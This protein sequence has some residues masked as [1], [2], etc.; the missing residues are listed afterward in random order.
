MGARP[1][2]DWPR[3]V[4]ALNHRSPEPTGLFHWFWDAGTNFKTEENSHDAVHRNFAFGK[5]P[6]EEF[7]TKT[8]AVDFAEAV[9]SDGMP[10]TIL[11]RISEIPAVFPEREDFGVLPGIDFPATLHPAW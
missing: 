1:G 4:L 5:R 11:M 6:I 3:R 7:E 9:A 2:G 10:S 8:K